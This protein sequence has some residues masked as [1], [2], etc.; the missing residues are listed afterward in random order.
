KM[1]LL[2]TGVKHSLASSEYNIRR[3]QCEDGANAI[4][5]TH[6]EV[7]SL[8]DVSASLLELHRN[9]LL[10]E[11]YRRCRFVIEENE[12]VFATC[13]NLQ[14]DDLAAAGH[15]LYD[16]HSG[17]KEKYEVSCKELDLLVDLVRDEEGVVG[18]RMMGGGF[19]GCTINLVKESAIESLV[20]KISPVYKNKTGITLQDYEVITGDG[21]N[22]LL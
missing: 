13:E 5:K 10:P 16:S 20:E 3:E 1:V 15:L 19:G 18:A 11:V 7:H 14:K 12:R 22:E 4:Q 17:L 6:P 8:R 21:A 9:K 2:D